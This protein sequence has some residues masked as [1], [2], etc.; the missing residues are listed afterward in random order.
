MIKFCGPKLR[1][2]KGETC[3]NVTSVSRD[4]GKAFSPMISNESQLELYG[5][6]IWN[7]ENGW[8]Y[9]RKWPGQDSFP[10]WDQW[11]R[12]GYEN[13][14]GIRYPVG[15][16]AIPEFSYITPQLGKMN[17]IES[18]KKIYLPLYFQKL[19]RFCWPEIEMLIEVIEKEP[20]VWIWDFDVYDE[21]K[22]SFDYILN[23]EKASLGHGFLVIK[24]I[25]DLINRDLFAEAV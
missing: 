21:H 14:Q 11:R 15:K 22:G 18:R 17:W 13:K 19:Q 3:V 4:F 2:P 6:K 20:V 5:H 1:P 7:V 23:S 8:Q 9:S 24:Y 16:G 25:S 12:A 10:E